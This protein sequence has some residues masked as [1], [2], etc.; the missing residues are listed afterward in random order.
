MS[1]V[2]AA[3]RVDT[4]LLTL[5]LGLHV[6]TGG[7]QVVRPG[8]TDFAVMELVTVCLGR[9]S[10][11]QTEQEGGGDGGQHLQLAAAPSQGYNRIEKFCLSAF[12]HAR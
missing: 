3:G 7:D 2:S 6:R 12:I 8:A 11:G 4:A 5:N 10:A 9:Q 1:E